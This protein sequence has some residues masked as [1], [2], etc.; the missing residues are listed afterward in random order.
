LVRTEHF[1]GAQDKFAD[2][3][4]EDMRLRIREAEKDDSHIGPHFLHALCLLREQWL[5]S[6]MEMDITLHTARAKPKYFVAA[7]ETV[8]KDLYHLFMKCPQ[9]FHLREPQRSNFP[10]ESNPILALYRQLLALGEVA[11]SI[12][13]VPE[14]QYLPWVLF[15]SIK[16]QWRKSIWSLL[17]HG[18]NLTYFERDGTPR[19]S[20]AALQTTFWT[21]INTLAEATA[22]T[23]TLIELIDITTTGITPCVNLRPPHA[24]KMVTAMWKAHILQDDPSA[25]IKDKQIFDEE[26]IKLLASTL[27]H[28][29][30][31]RPA[32]HQIAEEAKNALVSLQRLPCDAPRIFSVD[33]PWL[34][35]ERLV[36]SAVEIFEVVLERLEKDNEKERVD[37][38]LNTYVKPPLEANIDTVPLTVGK[39]LLE[40]ML[41]LATR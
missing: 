13:G 1:F 18:V 20:T 24:I 5:F 29:K 40:R 26:I 4:F 31:P 35:Q 34:G 37:V 32:I 11:A 22:A 7:A 15:T 28:L 36:S 10:P 25:P 23:M 12:M 30:N 38:T 17:F 9:R 16:P 33:E 6:A 14:F 8:L 27:A 2:K 39:K 41:P 21:G 3:L 19:N